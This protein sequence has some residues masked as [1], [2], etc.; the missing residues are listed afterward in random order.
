MGRRVGGSSGGARQGTAA[1]PPGA[2][3][4]QPGLA[5]PSCL[6]H[7][8]RQGVLGGKSL[9]RFCHCRWAARTHAPDPSQALVA[10]STLL[11]CLISNPPASNVPAISLSSFL[12][13]LR[14]LSR[15]QAERQRPGPKLSFNHSL[16]PSAEA[17]TAERPPP[18]LPSCSYVAT[19]HATVQRPHC[20][21]CGP[22]CGSGRLQA[23]AFR[24]AKPHS[25]T[26][27]SSCRYRR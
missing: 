6:E 8:R 2:A 26:G 15:A 20:G 21:P 18:S 19:G 16:L 9:L 11:S 24:V 23:C 25:A 14:K 1:T 4:C 10:P 13:L 3:S 7:L 5:S 27:A 17:A 12:F 22:P